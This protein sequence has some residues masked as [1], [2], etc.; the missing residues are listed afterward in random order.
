M[1]KAQHGRRY[2]AW[3]ARLQASGQRSIRALLGGLHLPE[4]AC[5]CALLAASNTP[6]GH[7][8]PAGPFNHSLQ[9]AAPAQ[10]RP[11]LAAAG[12]RGH[13]C[14]WET[15]PSTGH[16]PR[17]LLPFTLDSCEHNA[18]RRGRPRTARLLRGTA[19]GLSR[20]PLPAA[21][22]PL[23]GRGAGGIDYWRSTAGCRWPFGPRRCPWAE[24]SPGETL[25][26]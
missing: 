2:P 17:R 13:P 3:H 15:P 5:S 8:S 20:C 11:F 1:A 14:W 10:G 23:P 22:Q 6:G 24:Q 16:R 12:R 7:S 9:P 25:M 26:P 4:G 19:L 21:H 18:G